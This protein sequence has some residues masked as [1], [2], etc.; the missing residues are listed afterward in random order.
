MDVLLKAG[1]D[2]T[3][4]NDRGKPPLDLIVGRGFGLCHTFTYHERRAR[5]LL[6][7]A[8]RDRA[9]RAWSRRRLF[10][11]CR[12][13]PGRVGLGLEFSEDGGTEGCSSTKSTREVLPNN[14]NNSSKRPTTGERAGGEEQCFRTAMGR[15]MAFEEQ[16][17]RTIVEFLW[18]RAQKGRLRELGDARV[19]L[20][21][22]SNAPFAVCPTLDVCLHVHQAVFLSSTCF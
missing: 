2:E 1:A 8:P 4:V 19:F 9:D 22:S 3:A 12:A 13:F 6:R 21:D 18:W 15:L 14:H 20:S 11:L 5:S 16:C 7:N 17:F 10:V